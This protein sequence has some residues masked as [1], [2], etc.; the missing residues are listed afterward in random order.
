MLGIMFALMRICDRKLFRGGIPT[1]MLKEEFS[2]YILIPLGVKKVIKREYKY[3]S[4]FQIV[5]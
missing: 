5:P 4:L 1:E 3:Y 2:P